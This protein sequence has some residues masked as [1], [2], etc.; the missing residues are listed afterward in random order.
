MNLPER[1]RGGD[2][3]FSDGGPAALP[4]G[5]RSNA[6]RFDIRHFIAIFRR[7]LLLFGL[8]TALCT[9]L[10]LVVTMAMPE[11]FRA[12]TDVVINIDSATNLP[13]T[14]ERA[15]EEAKQAPAISTEIETLTSS[16]LAGEVF[17]RLE[18]AKDPRFREAVL[19]PRSTLGNLLERLGVRRA[20]SPDRPAG[21][22][23]D[24]GFRAA[25][26]AWLRGRTEVER[27]GDAYA[28]GVTITAPDPV[29]AAELANGLVQAY[30]A[31]KISSKAA[32]NEEAIETLKS[33]MD[34][35]REQ[36]QADFAAVQQYRV[37]NNLLS[38]A[39][40]G[41]AEGEVS[42]YNQEVAAARAS[43]SED[44]A[45]LAAARAQ[46]GRGTG[47]VGAG[48]ASAVVNA[49]RAQR[50]SLSANIA[51]MSERYV[52][53]HPD[54]VAAREQ[55]A[56]IDRQ[57][58]EEVGRTIKAL[59]AQA[60]TSRQRLTSLETSRGATR[61]ALVSNNRSL[62]A[63]EDLSRKAAAS[64]A[65][66]ESYLQRYNE[67]A[68][69]SG[70]ERSNARII[71]EARVPGAPSSPRFALNMAF[72]LVMGLL[73]GGAS[74]LA[75]EASYAGFTTREDVEDR[76]GIRFLAAVPLLG[77]T[78]A[79]SGGVLDTV[80]NSP[81]SLFNETLR[82]MLASIRQASSSRNQVI[83][84]TSAVPD[85]GKTTLSASLS[86]VLGRMGE[87]VCIVDCDVVRRDF[88]QTL[89]VDPNRP[90]LREALMGDVPLADAIMT[91]EAAGVAILPITTP[92]DPGVRLMEKGRLNRLIARLR[93]EYDVII[94][95]CPP[96]LPIAEVREIVTL[97]DNLVFIVR[98]RKTREAVVKA[99]L[100]LLP[101]RRLS[102]IGI[103]LNGVDL[104]R[105]IRFGY[106]DPTYLYKK[107]GKYYEE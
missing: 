93:E 33:R 24:D 101:L 89:A 29:L 28:L 106:D 9:L 77:S 51:Q 58:D 107:H 62:V 34:E 94:L 6:D 55:L 42:T 91:D 61:S 88:S 31:E 48:T 8:V 79:H 49:L 16:R 65:L 68:A 73:L 96:V 103:V 92:F 98:W 50:A 26:T 13:G 60:A 102:D 82:G 21:K 25:A 11:Q 20:R 14:D 95:D 1:F 15:A 23:S 47:N 12:R 30:G 97:A 38:A 57:I 56:D 46:L 52:P 64:Q 80:R 75:A 74:A 39:A 87:R 44:A 2:L 86:Y 70:A 5:G 54:L 67:V 72:G 76:L 36:A 99:A 7:R 32:D 3:L 45:R 41:M 4:T 66:Y 69:Q 71:S 19:D 78:G 35:L 59:E 40:T 37:K 18:L 100:K 10:S 81:G 85:E 83:A 53:G 63:L 17:D 27:I 84:M 104:N 90:G 22:A 105:R 43:A